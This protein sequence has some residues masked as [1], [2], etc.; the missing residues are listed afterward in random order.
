M[1]DYM[2]WPAKIAFHGVFGKKA[3]VVVNPFFVR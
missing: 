3:V 1:G 2:W